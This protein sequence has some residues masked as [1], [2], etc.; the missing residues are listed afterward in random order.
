MLGSRV[1]AEDAVQEAWMRASRAGSSEVDNLGGWLTTVVARICLDALRTRTARREQ[2]LDDG[3]PIGVDADDPERQA[4]LADAVGGA[5]TVVL[6]SLNPAERVAFV[7]HDLFEIPFEAVAPVIGKSVVA[8]RQLASRA[9]RRVRIGSADT[10]VRGQNAVVEAFLA[11]SR[12]GNFDALLRLLDPALVVRADTAIAN[13]GPGEIARGAEAVATFFAGRVRAA[14]PAL[15]DGKPGLA[16]AHG[17]KLRVA[18][19]FSFAEGR[20]SA[21]DLIA[22]PQRTDAMQIDY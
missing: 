14:Q 17:G 7:L 10:S 15:I 4:M 11:A 18:F 22:D 3:A 20:V 2:P 5:L 8:T 13:V 19:V 16:W 9:R 12:E 21:I 1:E 6:A